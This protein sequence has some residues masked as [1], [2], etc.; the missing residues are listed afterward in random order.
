MKSCKIVSGRLTCKEDDIAKYSIQTIQT[1]LRTQAPP[2]FKPSSTHIERKDIIHPIH[3]KFEKELKAIPE[4]HRQDV[5]DIFHPIIGNH[6]TKPN[7]TDVPQLV[8]EKAILAQASRE[9]FESNQNIQHVE[10][11]LNTNGLNNKYTIQS[12]QACIN[13]KTLYQV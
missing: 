3:D 5:R 4:K 10:Q 1:P 12:A 13:V 8:R 11:Y 6:V 7:A 9:Y 2:K